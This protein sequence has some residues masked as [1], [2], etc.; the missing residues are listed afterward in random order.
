[1]FAFAIAGAPAATLNVVNYGA[2][3]NGTGDSRTAIQNAINAAVAG[4]TVYFPNGT[5]NITGTLNGKSSV[6][7]TGQSQ[8]GA[9]VRFTGTA[10][11]PLI[12]LNILTGVEISYLTLEGNNNA[13]ADKGIYAYQGSGHNLHHLTIQN[14]PAVG[15]PLGIHFNGSSTLGTTDSTISDNTISNIGVTS[16]WGAGIR[17]S[18]NSS[19]NK[20]LRNTIS[21][22]GRGGILANDYCTDLVVQNNTTSGTGKKTE[23]L[24]VELWNGCVRGL[25]ED[26]NLDH[27][28]SL[29]GASGSAVR[30]NTVRDLAEN[31]MAWV[32][33]ELINA[34]DTVWTDNTVDHGQWIGISLSNDGAMNYS[35][36]AYNTIQY[37]GQWG[38]QFQGGT[39]GVHYQYL[40]K[41]KFLNTVHNHVGA[42][43]PSD[44]GH[45]FRFNGNS[46][47]VSLDS[48]EIRNNQSLGIQM[49]PSMDQL[50]VINTAITGNTGAAATAYGGVDLEWT[51]N[52]VTGNGDNTQPTSRG[53]S[54]TKPTAN[55]TAPTSAAIGQNVTFTSTSSD[56]GGSIAHYLWDFN[57]GL[58]ATS[59]SVTRSYSKAGTYRVSLV[60]WDKLGRGARV[61]KNIS[62][63]TAGKLLELQLNEG[64]GTPA[65]SSGKGNTIANSGATWTASGH[66]GSA[67][68]FLPGNLT[69]TGPIQGAL[70]GDFSLEAWIKLRSRPAWRNG[71]Y[72][73]EVYQS[74][75]FRFGTDASGHLCFWATE[76]GG[77]A[78]ITG[79]TVIAINTWTQVKVA[80]VGATFTIYVNGASQGSSSGT[81]NVSSSQLQIGR[82]SGSPAFDGFIDEI[83]VSSGTGL[84]SGAIYRLTPK[85]A[86]TRSLDIIGGGTADGTG[87]QIWDWAGNLQQ[88]FQLTDVGGGYYKLTPQHATTKA[89]DVNG[90]TSADGT[91]IQI[92]TDNGT[93]AQKWKFVDMGGGFYKVQP[94]CAPNSCLDVT[95][96]QTGN[97]TLVELW[98]DNGGDN[99]RWKLEMQ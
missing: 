43:Y 76:S 86:L 94:Q 70:T 53:F 75:G 96:A 21:T 27:W 93:G 48:C 29:D 10:L 77:T 40:Y 80:K 12:S 99:Q 67:M 37:C 88:K 42:P 39:G 35:Y 71:I 62:I 63:G 82:Y 32:G 47:Y 33:L 79:T 45:G 7:L 66:T 24:G 59:S 73:Q 30:R 65:D 89:L 41:T 54:N 13:N 91:K 85:M 34:V 81:Y 11:Q 14:F 49:G 4:D 18:W 74:N 83:L 90:A 23:G 2:Q 38:A 1:M 57:D 16:D 92:W 64:S 8:A 9:I 56:P 20:I 46:W 36:W 17:I 84:T 58:P 87:A 60:V 25:V 5:Y 98:T 6:K 3:G 44:S 51:G 68:D 97:G 72:C 95:G 28:I 55:F 26:N 19:R 50:S 52:T 22:T 69:A 31:V 61:E 15:G 78:D